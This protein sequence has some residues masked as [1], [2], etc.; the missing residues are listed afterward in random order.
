MLSGCLP[1]CTFGKLQ[2]AEF[3]AAVDFCFLNF[4]F[5]S[6]ETMNGNTSLKIQNS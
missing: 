5:F 3:L 2:P 1:A 6:L 4:F